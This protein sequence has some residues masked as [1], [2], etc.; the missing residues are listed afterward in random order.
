MALLA[1]LTDHCP[2]GPMVIEVGPMAASPRR[3]GWSPD[4]LR[5]LRKS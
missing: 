2:P 5:V 4:V 3:F 1:V